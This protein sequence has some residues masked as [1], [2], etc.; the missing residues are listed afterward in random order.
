MRY[1]EVTNRRSDNVVA[2]EGGCAS[3]DSIDV[4]G[5]RILQFV[6][7]AFLLVPL[8]GSAQGLMLKV[9][10]DDRYPLPTSFSWLEDKGGQMS[11]GD[12]TAPASQAAFKPLTQGGPGRQLR[13]HELC[14]LA[15]I[16]P[17][18]PGQW[19]GRLAGRDRLPAVGPRGRLFAGRCR[20]LGAQQRWRCAALCLAR[21]RP[22]Q[23][24]DACA[25]APWPEYA[26]PAHRVAGHRV[27][28]GDALPADVQPGEY[29]EKLLQHIFSNLLSNALKYSP[30][31]GE[32]RLKVYLSQG[33]VV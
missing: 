8:S 9:A 23:P 26:V 19:P 31:G 28:A 4:K 5:R 6:L 1:C 24:C 25:I 18:G 17:A 29:D 10:G 30:Q 13:P 11:I 20:H 2:L 21:H 3:N 27:G 12:I 15:Q 22:P 14:H 16:Q 32:V 7:V 33:R